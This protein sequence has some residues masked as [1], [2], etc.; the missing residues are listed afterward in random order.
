[1]LIKAR[2]VAGSQTLGKQ[3][4]AML[5]PFIYPAHFH[6]APHEEI[7]RIK[8]RIEASIR[9]RPRGENNI[10]LQAGGIR[11]IEFIV[12]CL[13]LLYGG[14]HPQARIHN[15]LSRHRPLGRGVGI[16]RSRGQRAKERVRVFSPH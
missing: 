6:S 5:R 10:K 16:D 13:Q 3:Y 7:R 12:Q 11:D 15:T 9:E 2:C 1:M 14:G 4:E 8:E